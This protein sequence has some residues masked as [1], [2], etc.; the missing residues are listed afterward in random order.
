MQ[1]PQPPELVEPHS[2]V[3][4]RGSLGIIVTRVKVRTKVRSIGTAIGLPAC[5]RSGNRKL[6][7]LMSRRF[8]CSLVRLTPLSIWTRISSVAGAREYLPLHPLSCPT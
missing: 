6:P 3:L 7:V 2:S 8:H 1:F 5:Q 4:R